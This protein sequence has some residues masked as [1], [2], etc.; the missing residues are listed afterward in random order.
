[1]TSEEAREVLGVSVEVFTVAQLKSAFRRQ[2]FLVHP[3]TGGNEE[4]FQRLVQ[5]FEV[6]KGS[7]KIVGGKETVEG[8]PL[9]EL[10]KG[11][12]LTQSAKTCDLCEGRG[13]RVFHRKKRQ[14]IKCDKC[15]GTGLN[16]YPCRKCDGEGTYVNSQGKKRRC[17]WCGGSG[18]FYPPASETDA[19]GSTAPLIPGTKKQGRIC[20]DCDGTGKVEGWEIDGEEEYY[21]VCE[22]CNGIGETQMFNPVLPRG[23]LSQLD[24][25]ARTP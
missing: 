22:R 8:R 12:P 21:A 5:A 19:Q 7:A 6:L 17:S 1:L 16:R 11:Y 18:W 2:S 9:S 10:G 14:T 3:D 24:K 23:F 15:G 13:Y 25:K 20:F 4:S